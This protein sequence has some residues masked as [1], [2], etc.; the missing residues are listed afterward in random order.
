ML[1]LILLKLEQTLQNFSPLKF[2]IF[3]KKCDSYRCDR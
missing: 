1:I 3:V 2:E